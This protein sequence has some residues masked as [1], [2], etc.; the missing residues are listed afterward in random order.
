MS[1]LPI[2]LIFAIAF[3]AVLVSIEGGLRIGRRLGAGRPGDTEKESPASA[4]SGAVLSLAAFVLSL[5]FSSVAD[6]FEAR[7]ELVRQEA[8]VIG[9]AFLRADFL[10]APQREQTVGLLRR[11]VDGR[12][13]AAAVRDP[14][15]LAALVDE[16]AALQDELWR[17]AVA[18]ARDDPHRQLASLYVQSLNEVFDVHSTRVAVAVQ[19][20]MMNE[21]WIALG[22]LV[23]L[24]TAMCVLR[25][26]A[27]R[28]PDRRA[29]PRD[30]PVREIP[31]FLETKTP[32]T[33]PTC[34]FVV[35]G[36]TPS[37]WHS[38]ATGATSRIA[39]PLR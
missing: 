13:Q 27:G 3:I 33:S 1:D 9:T 37:A 8:N 5:T 15:Q 10:P 28:R 6:R 20:R 38:R 35:F 14:A 32:C 31:P 39:T 29:E 11:Y 30:G 4:I 21:V 26:P 16:S 19:A 18:Y 22:V 36:F 23:C 24:G 25:W 7:K 12:L 2:P 34:S 17:I